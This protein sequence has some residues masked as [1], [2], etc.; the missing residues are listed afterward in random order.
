MLEPL[1]QIKQEKR[2]KP[3]IRGN[4]KGTVY[5]YTLGRYRWKFVKNGRTRASGIATNRT[6]AEKE[7]SKAIIQSNC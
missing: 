4:G 6:E 1:E 7:L 2:G 3:K 5:K